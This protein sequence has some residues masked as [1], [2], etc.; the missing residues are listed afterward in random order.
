MMPLSKIGSLC[1]SKTPFVSY[2]VNFPGGFFFFFFLTHGS[3]IVGICTRGPMLC[4]PLSSLSVKNIPWFPGAQWDKKWP[5]TTVPSAVSPELSPPHL[6]WGPSTSVRMVCPD[7]P[8]TFCPHPT[9]THCPRSTAKFTIAPR[10]K[11][12]LT[13]PCPMCLSLLLSFPWKKKKVL[14]ITFICLKNVNDTKI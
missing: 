13:P 14:I 2:S 7:P 6:T 12:S 11:V 5:P 4:F 1:S 10:G 3:A 9:R 8:R